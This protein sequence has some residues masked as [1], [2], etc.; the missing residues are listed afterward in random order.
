MAKVPS[1]DLSKPDGPRLVQ[2]VAAAV[3]DLGEIT[4]DVVGLQDDSVSGYRLHVFG[5]TSPS[6]EG[7]ILKSV[8]DTTFCSRGTAGDL[9]V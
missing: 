9:C 2:S 7:F 1:P 3:G 4:Y 5:T 6:G 8:E